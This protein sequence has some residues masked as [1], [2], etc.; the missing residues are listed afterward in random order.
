MTGLTDGS[1]PA[2]SS[3]GCDRCGAGPLSAVEFADKD[4]ADHRNSASL[5]FPERPLTNAKIIEIL[6][7]LHVSWKGYEY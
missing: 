2:A 3:S 5:A 1:V 4:G 7:P 6:R